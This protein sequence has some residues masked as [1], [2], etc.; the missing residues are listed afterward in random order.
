MG[1]VRN[2]S[3]V[4]TFGDAE[5]GVVGAWRAGARLG[6]LQVWVLALALHVVSLPLGGGGGEAQEKGG[7]HCDLGLN[8][9]YLSKA[10]LPEQRAGKSIRCIK[11]LAEV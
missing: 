3:D 9:F 4:H 11:R 8:R 5:F 6:L 2:G 1:S 7:R 10:P